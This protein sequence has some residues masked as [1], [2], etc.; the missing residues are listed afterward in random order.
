MDQGQAAR[1]GPGTNPKPLCALLSKGPSIP[2]KAEGVPHGKNFA[3][4]EKSKEHPIPR[5]AEGV[6]HGTPSATPEKSKEHPN[7][8]ILITG[9]CHRTNT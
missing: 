2:R 9:T 5:K 8:G 6:P 1:A 7:L 3:I 4:P